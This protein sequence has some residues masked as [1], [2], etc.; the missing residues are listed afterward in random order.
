MRK[1]TIRLAFGALAMLS[2]TAGGWLSTQTLEAKSES[3]EGNTSQ[4][5]ADNQIP[6]ANEEIDKLY[7]K[8]YELTKTNDEQMEQ[9]DAIN[10]LLIQSLSEKANKAEHNAKVAKAVASEAT[11]IIKESQGTQAIVKTVV[12]APSGKQGKPKVIVQQDV[13]SVI[14]V[15]ATSYIALCDTGCTGITATGIDVRDKTPNIIAVDPDII[16]LNRKVELFVNDKSIGIYE[17]QDTGGDIKGFRIDILKSTEREALNFG[18]QEVT[19]KII[20]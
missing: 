19:V 6:P 1:L 4:I 14:T 16:P 3:T 8:V 5:A 17:T 2:L 12:K 15:I 20:E 11:K 7:R 10:L 18:N 13:G 9:I